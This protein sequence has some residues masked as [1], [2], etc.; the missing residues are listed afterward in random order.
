MS[1]AKLGCK[2]IATTWIVLLDAVDQITRIEKD[3]IWRSFF[4]MDA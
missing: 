2:P 1:L 3:E 4:T